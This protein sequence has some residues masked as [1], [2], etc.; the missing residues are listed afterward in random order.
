MLSS[1]SSSEKPPLWESGRDYKHQM[2]AV[3]K[4]ETDCR[5]ESALISTLIQECGQITEIKTWL[6]QILHKLDASAYI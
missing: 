3:Q 6:G 2:G 1:F 4:N 5:L